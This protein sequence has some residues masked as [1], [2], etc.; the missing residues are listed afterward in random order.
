LAKV[1]FGSHAPH[2][3]CLHLRLGFCGIIGGLI[4]AEGDVSALSRE[5]ERKRTTETL[6]SASDPRDLTMKISVH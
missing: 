1:G 5:T 4:V 6:R 2:A 3:G